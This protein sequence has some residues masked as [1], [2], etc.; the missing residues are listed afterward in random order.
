MH[1]VFI[2]GL[3][4]WSMLVGL[5]A[6]PA[7]AQHPA[8]SQHP[9]GSGL[10]RTTS[11]APAAATEACTEPAL[12]CARS[13]TPAFAPDG[14]LW[15]AWIA[16]GVVSVAV[17]DDGGQH[18]SA[19][20]P[21]AAPD[22]M[23]DT[24]PDARAQIVA[25]PDGTLVV[26]WATFKDRAWNARLQ[27]SRSTDG[28]AHFS[29][30]VEPVTNPVSA[31]FPAMLPGA[32]GELYLAWL[33]K[34]LVAA[35]RRDG[36]A[37]DGASLAWARSTDAGAHFG[38]VRMAS[39]ASCECCRIALAL[40]P[41]DTPEALPVMVFRS[42]FPGSVRD[43]ARVAFTSREQTAAPTP[44]ADD[45]WVTSVCPH[46]GPALA[47]DAAGIEHVAWFTGGSNRQGLFYARSGEVDRPARPDA[48]VSFIEPQPVGV[49][50]EHAARPALIA[51]G[52]RVWLA[53]KALVDGETVVRVKGSTDNGRQW[54]EPQVVART[55]GYSDH[56]LLIAR[57]GQAA[58][59]WLTRREGYR[60]LDV[61]PRNPEQRP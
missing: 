6:T 20:Q 50:G 61:E 10:A 40:P 1:A 33:D 43:H 5:C 45:R 49:A 41:Q 48:R 21:L 26:V 24:G 30:P 15:L 53:W 34:R 28:G 11:P 36:R 60:L 37:A 25:T 54:S 12:R 16:A 29:A 19:A 55:R 2:R 52:N 58:L 3:A 27:L 56:P 39:N 38:E 14:R 47:I 18:F 31:R 35:Q 32:Q 59:S 23:M 51:I 4:G 46:Q 22:A 44:I 9:V 57:G 42:I 7:L 13:A 8:G 17:S